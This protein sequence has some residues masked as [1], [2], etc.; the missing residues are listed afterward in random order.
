MAKRKANDYPNFIQFYKPG[1]AEPP[2]EENGWQITP[3]SPRPYKKIWCK[4]EVVFREQLEAYVGGMIINR[5][6]V[7]LY[8]RMRQDLDSTMLFEYEGKLFNIALHGDL[9]GETQLLG[10]VSEDGGQ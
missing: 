5:N 7:R 8:M 4:V 1:V 10:E 9:K 2:S 3:G 6:R